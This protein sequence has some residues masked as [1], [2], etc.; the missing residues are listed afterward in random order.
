MEIKFDHKARYN[1]APT[2]KC[3][4]VTVQEENRELA[5]MHW[6]LIPSWAKDDKMASRLINAR[7][8]TVHEKPSFKE[9]FKTKRCLVPADGFIEWKKNESG[10]QPH[11]F[12]LRDEALFAFAGIWSEWKKDGGSLRT[13]S[14]ITTDCNSLVQPI[15]H[16]MP[17]IL[18][19][20]DYKVWLAPASDLKTLQ[21]L[22]APFPADLMKRV[23]V[24]PEINSPK[25]DR[26]ECLQ[27]TVPP[28]TQTSL[29]PE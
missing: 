29:F 18:A 2:Q 19:P 14:I 11:Y 24:S 26:M 15:H 17:V 16:R 6:G 20:G 27:R 9:S 23:A 4:V 1:I 3:P 8:E 22:L 10:K 7:A 12:T 28:K 25:N 21:S 13:F 5:A